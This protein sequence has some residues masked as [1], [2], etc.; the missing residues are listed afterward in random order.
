M[1]ETLTAGDRVALRQDYLEAAEEDI[2]CVR[3]INAGFPNEFVVSESCSMGGV[4]ALVLSPCCGRLRGKGGVTMCDGHPASLFRLLS[5]GAPGQSGLDGILDALLKTDP[6]RFFTVDLPLL[7]PLLQFAH[8]EDGK[9]EG[10]VLRLAGMKPIMV[11]GRD[12]ESLAGLIAK[13]RPKPKA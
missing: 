7:G 4:D 13:L 3:L 6:K 5:R 1:S 2:S 12:L 11:A 9:E 8:Y 10:L